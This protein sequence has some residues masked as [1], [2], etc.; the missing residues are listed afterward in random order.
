[1]QMQLVG[2]WTL[3]MNRSNAQNN[4]GEKHH[5]IGFESLKRP[6]ETAYHTDEHLAQKTF[7]QFE[8]TKDVL[9]I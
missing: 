5:V 9:S 3:Q 2:K 1:M 7:E 8:Q 4:Y 6:D